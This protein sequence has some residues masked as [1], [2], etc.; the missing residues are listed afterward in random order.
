[1]GMTYLWFSFI[2][3]FDV[4]Y[5]KWLTVSAVAPGLV[6]FVAVVAVLFPRT[7]ARPYWKWALLDTVA[8]K[9]S[10]VLKLKRTRPILTRTFMR[11]CVLLFVGSPRSFVY[12]RGKDEATASSIREDIRK[13]IAPIA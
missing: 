3:S 11:E 1:V 9:L 7:A 6:L 2:I 5:L 12:R 13:L 4:Q 8:I 10:K